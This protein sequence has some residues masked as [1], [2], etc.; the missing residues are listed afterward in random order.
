MKTFTNYAEKKA[1]QFLNLLQGYT[2]GI[3]TTAILILLLMGVSNAWAKFVYLTPDYWWKDDNARFAVYAWKSSDTNQNQWYSMVAVESDL[4]IACIDDKYDKFAYCRMNPDNSNNDWNNKWNQTV[5]LSVP[6]DENNWLQNPSQITDGSTY[7]KPN[8]NWKQSNARF[9]AYFFNNGEEWVD[10][11]HVGDDIYECQKKKDDVIFCRMNP[12]T[13]D[14]N[15]NNKWNQTSDLKCNQNGNI[16]TVEEGTWDKGGGTWSATTPKWSSKTITWDAKYIYLKPN[17]NWKQSN[18]RFAAYV[19]TSCGDGTWIDLEKTCNGDYYKSEKMIPAN[20]YGVIFCRMNPSTPANNWNNKWNQTGDLIIPTDGKNLFTV[21]NEAWDGSTTTW[22]TAP[23]YNITVT[24][25]SGTEGTITVSPGTT[26]NI[27]ETVTVTITPNNN[28]KIKLYTIGN[29]TTNVS[30][31]GAKSFDLTICSETTISA[32]FELSETKYDVTISSAGNGTV[33]PSGTQKVGA[34]GINIT[35]TANTGY[36]FA[37]WAITGGASVDNANSAS[38]KVTATATGAATA[39]FTEIKHTITVAPNNV[40]YGT[41]SPASVTAGI[42]TGSAD[43]KATPKTGYEFVNWEATSGITLANAKSAT[44]NITKATAAGSVTANFQEK[45]HDVTVSYKCGTTTIKDNT[46]TS[47]VGEVTSTTITA[48]D[49]IYGY[50]FNSWELGSGI[51]QTSVNGKSITITTKSS[52]DCTLTAK[53]DEDLTTKWF[54]AHTIN[55]FSTTSHKFTKKTGESSGNVAYVSLDLEANTHYEFKV[56][57]GKWYGNNN[58]GEQYW[59]KST[60]ENWDFY[61]DAGNCHM[62]S[63]VA[64]TYTFK[65]DF[66]GSNPKVSVYFPTSYTV[67]YSRVPETA[68]DAPTTSPSVNSG[69]LVLSGTSMTFTAKDAKDGYTWKGWYSNNTGEGDALT[70]NK[71]YTTAITANTTIYAV[72]TANTYTVELNQEGA[73]TV[74]TESVTATYGAAM[75]QIAP[76]TRTGYTFLG[77]WTEKEGKGTKYYNANGTSARNWDQTSDDILYAHWEEAQYT[78]T[79]GVHS[80]GNGKIQFDNTN[81]VKNGPGYVTSQQKYGTSISFTATPN[82]GYEIEGWYSDANCTQRI[83]VAGTHAKYNPAPVTSD[84]TV[85]VKFKVETRRI[86]LKP[87]GDNSWTTNEVKPRYVVYIKN[88]GSNNED[89][90]WS[91]A[92]NMTKIDDGDSDVGNDIYY[93]DILKKYT[94]VIFCRMDPNNSD[95]NWGNRW[96]QTKDLQI[97]EDCNLFDVA[98]DASTENHKLADG[99]WMEYNAWQLVGSFSS[100]DPC[101]NR[102]DEN[103]DGT[104]TFT[105]E[106]TKGSYEFKLVRNGFWYGNN[107]TMTRYGTG[108]QTGGWEMSTADNN[109]NIEADMTGNY[110]F[111]IHTDGKLTVTYPVTGYQLKITM[112]DRTTVYTSNSVENAGDIFSFFAPGKDETGDKAGKVELCFEG[113]PIADG[114][115]SKDLFNTSNVYVAK[116]NANKNGITDVALY[117]GDYYIRTD[118]AS[119][120]WNDYKQNSNKMTYFVPR[121]EEKY[122]YYWVESVR[123]SDDN[124]RVNVKACVGNQYNNDLAG[125][126]ENDKFTDVNGDVYIQDPTVNGH[127]NIERVNLRFGYNPKTNH[128]ERAMLTGS[129]NINSFLNITDPDGK[130]YKTYKNGKFDTPLTAR[131]Q[132]SK[133]T[134]I[135]NWVYE[136]DI[137]VDVPSDED[138]V[139]T[140]RLT[141]RA[142][143]G[144]DNSLFGFDDEEYKVPTQR[145]IVGAGSTPGPKKMRVIYDFKTNRMIMAWMPGDYNC[146]TEETLYADVLFMRHENDIVP[147]LNIKDTNTED[148]VIPKIVG[149]QSQFFAL[150]FDKYEKNQLLEEQYWITL[151]FNCVVGSISGVPGYMQTWGIQR[152]NGTK[153]AKKGWFDEKETFWEWMG[154]DDVMEAGVGYVLSFDKSAATWSDFDVHDDNGNYEKTISV[155]RLYFPSTEEGFTFQSNATFTKEYVNEPCTIQTADRYKQD[156]NWKIIGPLS[157]NSATATP[158]YAADNV[159]KPEK[160]SAHIDVPD[161]PEGKYSWSAPMFLYEFWQ[162]DSDRSDWKYIVRS[163]INHTYQAFYGYMVQYAGTIEWREISQSIQPRLRA[164]TYTDQVPTNI[165][166]NLE[167]LDASGR[168]HDQTFV[169]LDIE[170]TTTF[171]LNKDLNKVFNNNF[172]NLY[173]L[174]EDIPFAGNTLP[175][176]KATVPVGVRI[177]TAGEYTFRMPNGTE[178]ISVILLDKQTG[179]Q[180]NMLMEGYTVTLN[181]GTIENRFYLVVDPDRAA[182][183]VEN[184]G[185]EAKGDKSKGVE[186]FLID[187]KLFIRTAD[188][189]FDAKGQRL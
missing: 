186:K 172:A 187:G 147:Q 73:T 180:T 141:A 84:V 3:R 123:H 4:Y 19:F 169:S 28:Y 146:T 164:R 57:N 88:D 157:Y 117:D 174:S 152:Y 142:Y 60:S 40:N 126:L 55:N 95:N 69:N 71:D 154:P 26:V 119:G 21:P 127:V 94:Y 27:G 24:T 115:I 29:S 105:I 20:H 64:G 33:E 122:S 129:G 7:L 50:K 121:A 49:D 58:S 91:E 10:M 67:T 17:S 38:T 22:E 81:V 35:A 189:I 177:V 59:I 143:N 51:T 2:K 166:T 66:S 87:A 137:W 108:V 42:A 82:S 109:C 86:Y 139:V 125:M 23:T 135:S 144:A 106:L 79:F 131:D 92:V 155:L 124:N 25:P 107:G 156:G 118:G 11:K 13:T 168:Q 32:E 181:A 30:E 182:T 134:D 8:S 68:A 170:G 77:Y 100:W 37:N 159:W 90:D 151:P 1:K 145:T 70:A 63:S 45:K 136:R 148:Q 47:N 89:T 36:Q 113:N 132:N 9:A 185:E 78:V 188:G 179:A 62:K 98:V 52:G 184:V 65:I 44:T 34:S 6:T 74:G 114:I 54:L 165:T 138:E 97:L 93:A 46:T 48:P 5:D 161:V 104:Y 183:S 176:E 162:D 150:E 72:Y 53:Y 85:Y 173:T 96:T 75:P 133:F 111:T 12:S 140:V 128:F 153:R 56:Y 149:I 39:H 102:F 112:G 110:I 116:L 103:K 80:S 158:K 171:D 31:T 18:A 15:W 130:I 120:G 61:D 160:D 41:V 101:G 83:D 99:D 14:N 178:G 43:I 76:P 163:T 175:M 16:Y 167:L